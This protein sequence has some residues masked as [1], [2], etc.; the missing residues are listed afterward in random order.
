MN[1][2]NSEL[3]MNDHRKNNFSYRMLMMIVLSSVYLLTG[4]SKNAP[5]Y[6]FVV[7]DGN[8]LKIKISA[9]NDKEV[10]FYT[11]RHED[12][13]INFF[14]RT[15]ENGKLHT[16]YDACYSCYKYKLGFQAENDHV[17]CIACNLK[18]KLSDEFWDYIGACA[19]IPLSSIHRNEFIEIKLGDVQKGK[20]LF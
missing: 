3:N 2:V 16:H 6:Q 8:R 15:D 11:F 7:P 10:H 17:R 12:K 9:V 4:C 1:K 20:K 13:N 18:Y 19:P 5:E 14:V